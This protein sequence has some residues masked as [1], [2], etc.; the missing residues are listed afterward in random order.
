MHVKHGATGYAGSQRQRY[1]MTVCCI[2]ITTPS[3]GVFDSLILTY[4]IPI[5][6]EYACVAA[7]SAASVQ[8]VRVFAAKYVV[9]LY[10]FVLHGTFWSNEQT[11]W[12]P[13]LCK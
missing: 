4:V 9:G 5:T 2:S 10:V 12:S 13:G 8:V 7:G 6:K 3:L 11:P 1:T